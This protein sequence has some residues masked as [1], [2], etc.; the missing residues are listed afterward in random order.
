MMAIFAG[1]L[2]YGSLYLIGVFAA[3]VVWHVPVASKLALID[4]GV[5]YL[6]FLMQTLG[7]DERAVN[8]AVGLTI[9][10][11]ILAGAMLLI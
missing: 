11:G 8:L 7:A 2:L 3:G 4:A 6:S 10:L 5:V 9:G 1:V